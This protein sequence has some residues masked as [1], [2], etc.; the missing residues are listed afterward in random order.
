MTRRWTSAIMFAGA[1]G[2][3]RFGEYRRMVGGISGRML[4][5]RLRELEEHRSL[6]QAVH[7]VASWAAREGR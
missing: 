4:T 5:L 2:A 3:R 1:E 6:I 7:A